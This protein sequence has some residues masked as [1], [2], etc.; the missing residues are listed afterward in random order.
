MY[1]HLLFMFFTVQY[2][3]KLLHTRQNLGFFC[4]FTLYSI[5][6]ENNENKEP[7]LRSPWNTIYNSYTDT[8]LVPR[9]FPWKKNER[10]GRPFHFFYGKALGTRLIQIQMN[11]TIKFSPQFWISSTIDKSSWSLIINDEQNR[12]VTLSS[13]KL[14]LGIQINIAIIEK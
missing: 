14:L 7:W 11:S 1:T 9:A 6:P 13:P 4:L 2:I 3:C 8:N 12:V 5:N 10:G